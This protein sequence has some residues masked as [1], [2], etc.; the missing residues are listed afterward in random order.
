MRTASYAVRENTM[1]QPIS[2]HR[3][4]Q[5]TSNVELL[6]QQKQS[7]LMGKVN[8]GSYT[9]EAA[10][11]VAQFGEVEFGDNND[12][13]GPTTFSDLDHQ[14]RWV[15]PSDKD[16]AL[17][18]AKEEEI[19]MITSPKS[20]YAE[21]MRA[22]YAR[23]YDRMVINGALGNNKIGKYNNLQT[24]ALPTDQII[25]DGGEGLTLEKLNA[26]R[27]MFD[28]AEVDD[29]DTRY[30]ALSARQVTNL[31][32]TTEVKSADYNTVKA[33]VKGELNSFMGFEFVRLQLLPLETGVRQCLAW[34]KSGLHV[35]IW[36]N[37]ETHI[38]QRPDLKYLWQIYMKCTTGA[39]RTQE[40]KVI[41]VDCVES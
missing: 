37:L 5:F 1:P 21:A 23:H 20:P 6:L 15:F 29:S 19:R 2:D 32:E 27:E 13:Y 34:V 7:R 10:R 35:G 33:L 9:G 14:Q 18:V 26:M 30:L 3:T 16:L 12:W 28:A 17:K 36:N 22:A 39:T 25:D 41:R 8:T 4:I 40:K 31:L 38:D 24:V 11:P